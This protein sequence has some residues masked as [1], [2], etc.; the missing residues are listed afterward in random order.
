MSGYLKNGQWHEGWYDT[1]KT[2]GAFVRTNSVFRNWVKAD[3]SSPYPAMP[4]RYH[5]YVSLACPWAHRTLIVRSLKKLESIVPLSI[6]EPVMT[7]GWAFSEALPD[8]ANG[9]QFMHQLYT[10]AQGDYT[11]RVLVPVLWDTVTRSIVS[12]E[13]ADIV[14]MFDQAFTQ[15]ADNSVELY[16]EGL[17]RD[18]DELN[19]FLYENINNGVYRCGF[20]TTQD[21][22]ERAFENLFG[23]LDQI[24]SRL[25]GSTFLLGDTIT[26]SDWRLFT[27]LAR[28]DAVYV[29]HFKCNRNR[30]DDFSHLSR[31]L[32][33]LYLQP[34]I[35]RTVNMDHIKRHYYLSHPHINPSGIVPAGPILRFCAPVE[36]EG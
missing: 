28:F 5:L 15:W 13:S 36:D 31:Y 16:P 11:G 18:I 29:G 6:V 12:N 9:F 23:A 4:G 24:E 21:A 20:A 30:I 1:G 7:Q 26:E 32:R 35:A 2:S 8:H 14:R 33:Q 25:A 19:D 3:P 27:T 10:A 22:Y 17:R 34:G